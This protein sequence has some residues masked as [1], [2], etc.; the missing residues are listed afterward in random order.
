MKTEQP[1]TADF[2]LEAFFERRKNDGAIEPRARAWEMFSRHGLPNR[3]VESWHY[4]DLRAA[5]REISPRATE[6]GTVG[7]RRTTGARRH[8]DRGVFGRARRTRRRAGRRAITNLR[9]ALARG[10]AEFSRRWRRRP[11]TPPSISTPR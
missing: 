4:T 11:M 7:W 1:T 5:L 6:T 3:R 8:H 9:D 10:D 2:A